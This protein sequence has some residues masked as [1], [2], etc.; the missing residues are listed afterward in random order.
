[1]TFGDTFVEILGEMIG[2]DDVEDTDS[3]IVDT[4]GEQP[5]AGCNR[6]RPLWIP[7]CEVVCS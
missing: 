7:G 3:R 4:G 2:L 6:L 5:F 1:M